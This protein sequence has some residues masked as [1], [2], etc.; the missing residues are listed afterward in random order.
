MV[1][2]LHEFQGGRTR[3]QS[4]LVGWLGAAGNDKYKAKYGIFLTM[5]KQPQLQ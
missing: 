5:D 4:Q 2:G 3:Q 1:L